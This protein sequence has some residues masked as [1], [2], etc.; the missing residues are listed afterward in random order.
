MTMMTTNYIKRT[1]FLAAMGVF[2]SV[3]SGESAEDRIN[4]DAFLWKN[5]PLLLFGP[6]PDAPEYRVLNTELKAQADQII[7]RDMVI[8]EIFDTG[9]V[10]V[11]GKPWPAESAEKLRRQF[12]VT[13]GNLTATLIGKD[14]GQK[15]RQ[16]QRI[17]LGSIFAL[18]DTMPMRQQEMRDK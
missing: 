6:S 9:L 8:I 15:L 14:G 4:F 11:D 17:D 10:R 1:L 13:R 5:R 16:S 7:D 3:G 2:V 12:S 18:I